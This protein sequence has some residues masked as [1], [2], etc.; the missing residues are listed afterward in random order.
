MRVL[1]EDDDDY[2]NDDDDDKDRHGGVFTF[3]HACTTTNLI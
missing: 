3:K 2:C 1:I